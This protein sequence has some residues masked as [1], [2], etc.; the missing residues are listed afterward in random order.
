MSIGAG[1][2]R[3][4]L[5]SRVANGL[6]ATLT[7]HFVINVDVTSLIA[8]RRPLNVGRVSDVSRKLEFPRRTIHKPTNQKVA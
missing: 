3:N 4:E 8:K 1:V 2:I 5:R 7:G 6:H